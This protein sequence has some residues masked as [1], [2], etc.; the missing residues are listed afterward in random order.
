MRII[1][2]LDA[3]DVV[4]YGYDY[5][6]GSAA[7]LEG[8]PFEEIKKKGERKRVKK[9]LAPLEP[10]AILC[11]GLNYHRHAQETGAVIPSHPVLFMKNPAALNNPEDPIV[12]PSS[13]LDPPQVDYEAELAVVI[14]KAA[15]NVPAARALEHVLGYTAANDVS[16][17]RWQ[18]HAGGGQWVKGKSFDS[19]CPLGPALVT[20]DEIPDP[21]SLQLQCIL[22]GEV[23]QETN[24]SDMIFSVAVLIEF[25]STGMTLKPGT[26]ILTG[27]PSGVGY[28]RK[29]PVYLK[30]GDRVEIRIE[31]IGSLINP[32]TEEGRE[33]R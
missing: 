13:C 11:I 28:V 32:V 3:D 20:P 16:A 12:L 31:R 19:F 6:D 5:A 22:N 26:V 4:R 15:K 21:Q 17:R 7:V 25:L 33:Q 30:A 18:K 8:N 9:L 14:G 1:R 10:A 2:F 29:P 27:T 23:M 24:T